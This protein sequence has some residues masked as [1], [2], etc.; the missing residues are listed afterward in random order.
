MSL[1]TKKKIDTRRYRL[2][3]RKESNQEVMQQSVLRRGLVRLRFGAWMLNADGRSYAAYQKYVFFVTVEDRGEKDPAI[4]KAK[5]FLD[6]L[7]GQAAKLAHDMGM[8]LESPNT[9][10][11]EG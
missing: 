11:K 5:K 8:E 10:F 3:I 1:K 6:A 2:R 9:V 4:P 7:K